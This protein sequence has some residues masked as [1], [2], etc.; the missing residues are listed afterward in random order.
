MENIQTF[1]RLE[2]WS[3]S[4]DFEKGKVPVAMDQS[5]QTDVHPQIRLGYDE[6]QDWDNQS[7]GRKVEEDIVFVVETEV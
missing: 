4:H 6:N 1:G 5:F 7:Q 2:G 3:V